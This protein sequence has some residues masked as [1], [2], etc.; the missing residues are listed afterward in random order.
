MFLFYIN[1][2]IYCYSPQ[3]LYFPYRDPTRSSN[4]LH[5]RRGIRDIKLSRAVHNDNDNENSSNGN[6][7][8]GSSNSSRNNSSNN[9]SDNTSSNDNGSSND[10]DSGTTTNKNMLA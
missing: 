5:W 8:N 7:N 3:V 2:Y 1:Y 4:L 10:N 9:N 6:S